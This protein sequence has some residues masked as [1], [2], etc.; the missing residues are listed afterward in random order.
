MP[1]KYSY[2]NLPEADEYR[3][4]AVKIF[5]EGELFGVQNEKNGE[6]AVSNVPINK[7]SDDLDDTVFDFEAE[8]KSSKIRTV[9]DYALY[10]VSVNTYTERKLRDKLRSKKRAGEQ[11]YSEPQIDEAVEYL[12]GFG[13]INDARLAQNS[14][15]GLAERMWGRVKIRFYLIKNGIDEDIVDSLDYSDIDF[16]YYCRK[17][18]AKHA[19][20]PR[21]KQYRALSNAGYTSDEIREAIGE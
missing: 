11:L 7:I 16:N 6:K 5:D 14:L 1:K 15:L 2:S 10:L 8:S 3:K 21:E 4:R 13:Y 19:G 12:K 17:L 18:L 20:K 9:K